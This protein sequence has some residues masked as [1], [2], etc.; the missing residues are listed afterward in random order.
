MT[1]RQARYLVILSWCL[2]FIASIWFSMALKIET[3]KRDRIQ[4]G[5]YS[6][7]TWVTSALLMLLVG[8]QWLPGAA[9]TVAYIKMIIK[10]RRD[11]VI[12]PADVS[13]SSQNRHRRNIRAA[14]ILAIEVLF[15]LGCLFPFYH[16]SIATITGDVRAASPLT[17]EGTIVFCAMITYSLANPFCHILLN[18]EFREEVKKMTHQLKAFCGLESVQISDPSKFHLPGLQLYD[19]ETRGNADRTVTVTPTGR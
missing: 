13:Q 11:A 12:N 4:C 16:N 7:K 18:S 8:L 3:D 2:G 19:E 6:E 9:F 10:L 1:I 17:L 15:F 5:P 14:R